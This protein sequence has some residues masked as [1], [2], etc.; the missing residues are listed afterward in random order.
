MKGKKRCG[1]TDTFLAD[2]QKKGVEEEAESQKSARDLGGGGGFGGGEG[3]GRRGRQWWIFT[4]L[5]LSPPF[6]GVFCVSV[7]D[8]PTL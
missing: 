6:I 1:Q 4:P 2:G 7:V 5:H 8:V 3:G